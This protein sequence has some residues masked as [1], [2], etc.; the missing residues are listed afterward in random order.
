LKSDE[1]FT[2][3]IA[4]PD[5][6]LTHFKLNNNSNAKDSAYYGII[7]LENQTKSREINNGSSRS[8]PGRPSNAEIALEE[9]SA[10]IDDPVSA[11]FLL[12]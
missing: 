9:N 7:T 11:I 5:R 3:K 1:D 4:F 12:F 6:E 8:G 10:E 2:P